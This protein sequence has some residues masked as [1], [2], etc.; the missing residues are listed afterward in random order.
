MKKWIVL[1]AILFSACTSQV[2]VTS[3]VIVTSVPLSTATPIPTPTLNPAFVEFQEKIE[4]SGTRFTLNGPDGLIYDGESPIPGLIVAP[5]G[6]MTLTINS[7]IVP[8]D[9]SDVSFDDEKGIII[10]GYEQDENGV[11]VEAISQG[12]KQLEL[13]VY[14]W[15]VDVT[16]YQVNIG[17]NGSTTLTSNESGKV[18]YRDGSWE[19]IFL[20]EMIRDSKDGC[21]ILSDYVA[22]KIGETNPPNAT[23]FTEEYGQAITDAY[24][25]FIDKKIISASGMLFKYYNI[26]QG[27]WGKVFYKQK[28]AD[29]PIAWYFWKD[30]LGRLKYEKVFV[31]IAK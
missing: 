10:N 25:L 16:N 17:E 18:V 5:N 12:E 30:S 13:D 6:T 22:P 3:K 15:D 7:E 4:S 19:P 31:N 9:P 24:L 21:K 14:K 29:Q 26:G 27:C 8:L 28:D 1:I 20:G 23:K 11:W 2:T